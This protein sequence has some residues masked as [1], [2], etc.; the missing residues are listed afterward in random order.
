M[1]HLGFVD[2]LVG[3]NIAHSKTSDLEVAG[4]V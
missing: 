1:S 2:G 4:G 3:V